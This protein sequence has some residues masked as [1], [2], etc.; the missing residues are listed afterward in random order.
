MNAKILGIAVAIAILGAYLVYEYTDARITPEGRSGPDESWSNE[1]LARQTNEFGF[2]LYSHISDS[3]E[4]LFFSPV[5]IDAVFAMVYEGAKGDT[6][7]SMQ[8]RFGFE[9]DDTQR[10]GQYYNA[11][12]ILNVQNSQYSLNTANA[13]WISDKYE[14]NSGY[15]DVA[16]NHYDGSVQNV[17]FVSDQGVNTINS[18]VN[19]ETNGK[20]KKLFELGSTDIL[21]LVAITNA[22]YFK[23]EWLHPF[24]PGFTWES[25]FFVSNDETVTVHMMNNEMNPIRHMQNDI[26]EII[27]LPYKGDKI[28]ML[29]M[30]PTEK[31]QISKLEREMSNSNLKKW[32]SQLSETVAGVYIP[33]FTAEAYYDL[34]KLLIRMGMD[35]PF[36]KDKADLGGIADYPGIYIDKAAHKAAVEVNELGTEAAAA[37]GTMAKLQSGPPVIFRANHPFVYIIQD[38]HSEQILFMGRVMDPTR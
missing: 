1:S 14:L 9:L 25:E 29:V 15:V 36:D 26:V 27:E 22:I 7:E 30:L 33:K 5:S 11:T 31:N 17:N 21:T 38:N 32:R 34:K 19:E 20:I 37:T 18:W 12:K 16:K 24:E 4:N 3:D 13:L 28:S 8:N 2:E 10:R 35:L 23:G 6:A